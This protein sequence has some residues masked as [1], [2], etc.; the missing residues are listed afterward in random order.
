M[1]PFDQWIAETELRRARKLRSSEYTEVWSS[2]LRSRK[3]RG[4]PVTEERS[5]RAEAASSTQQRRR[6]PHQG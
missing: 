6:A 1:T 3:M 2:M 4:L 5:A